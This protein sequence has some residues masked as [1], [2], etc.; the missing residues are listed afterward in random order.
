MKAKDTMIAYNPDTG[1]V[2]VGPWP[3]NTGWSDGP[4]STTGACYLNRH[5]Y[6]K[7]F[8]MMVFID[9]IHLIVRD[10]MD[11]M[12]VHKALLAIDEYVDGCSDDMPGIKR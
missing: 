4:Y 2:K 9:A 12:T 5:K 6:P 3:D 8:K 1:E 11:P 10:K 7:C